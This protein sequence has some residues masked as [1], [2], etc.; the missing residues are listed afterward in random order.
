MHGA[1]DSVPVAAADRGDRSKQPVALGIVF[2]QIRVNG[3]IVVDADSRDH[4]VVGQ[5]VRQMKQAVHSVLLR[6]KRRCIALR[7]IEEAVDRG[8]LFECVGY[9]GHVGHQIL[10]RRRRLCR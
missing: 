3:I 2:H 9:I 8:R 1:E 10:D 5:A 4:G 7:E 6:L